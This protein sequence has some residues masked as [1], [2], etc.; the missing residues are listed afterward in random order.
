MRRSLPR[1]K[2][3]ARHRRRNADTARLGGVA[4]GGSGAGKCSYLSLR[5]W[6]YYDDDI[7]YECCR[8]C[9]DWCSYC[10]A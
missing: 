9:C 8:Y 4:V 7:L 2:A 3:P 1:N 10:R 5:W 6:A